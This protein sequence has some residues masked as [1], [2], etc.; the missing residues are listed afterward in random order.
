V[1][2]IFILGCGFT[3][4]RV[5]ARLLAAGHGVSGTS[6]S[7]DSLRDLAAQGLRAIGFDALEPGALERLANLIP[8][9]A[10]VL[11]SIPTLRT[12]QGLFEPTPGLV[13]ALGGRPS[14]VVYLSTTGV[15]G[16][17]RD[18]GE[19]TPAAPQTERQR[20]RVAAEEAVRSG[21]W[22]SLIL[23]PAAI[24]GP[25]RGVQEALPRGEYKLAGD[26]SNYVSRIHADDLAA[27]AAA[28]LL[29][30]ITGTFPVADAH[31]CSSREIAGFVSGLLRIPLPETVSSS[32]LSETRRSDRRVDGSAILRRLG[33]SL[34]Y[35]SY[36]EGIPAALAAADRLK[37]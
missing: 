28:A 34:R 27:V 33:I 16:A 25:G 29:A 35:P 37:P 12:A 4:R 19:S 22:R 10:V 7:A 36:R 30:D 14:R 9:G 15:Y 5:A 8:E 17:A 18:V 2:D 20:L 23:R 11:D 13:K 6:R 26:G 31:P 3:G 32:E 24:Y 1:A 21:P